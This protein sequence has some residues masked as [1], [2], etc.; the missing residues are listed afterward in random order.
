MTEDDTD[1]ISLNMWEGWKKDE[2]WSRLFGIVPKEEQIL[3]GDA[4]DG[5]HRSRAQAIV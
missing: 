1:K 5:I 3:R 4:K 2:S